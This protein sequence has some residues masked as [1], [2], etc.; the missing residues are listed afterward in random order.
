MVE[1]ELKA[2]QRI[3]V[4]LYY[5]KNK[6][7]AVTLFE[8]LKGF[9]NRDELIPLKNTSFTV[10]LEDV[11]IESNQNLAGNDTTYI[12]TMKGELLNG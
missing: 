5:G 1:F 9:N 7:E 6:V 3:K 2:G 12:V 4:M 8:Y 10:R 11:F